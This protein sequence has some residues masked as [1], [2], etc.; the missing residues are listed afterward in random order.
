M[1]H[2]KPPGITPPN[3]CTRDGQEDESA[4][5]VGDG[6]SDAAMAA[7]L[8]P[9]PGRPNPAPDEPAR[10]LPAPADPERPPGD[11]GDHN[12]DHTPGR[13]PALIVGR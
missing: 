7:G 2:L 9:L 6:V 3:P 1:A 12:A 10:D 5:P 13:D 4:D 8:P 11:D